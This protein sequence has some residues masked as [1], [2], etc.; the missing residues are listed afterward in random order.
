MGKTLTTDLKSGIIIIAFLAI[1]SSLAMSH[2]W[3]IVLF[4]LH[5]IRANGAPTDGLFRQQQVLLRSL[6]TPD[7]MLADIVKLWWIWRRYADRPLWRSLLHMGLSI[8]FI[9]ATITVSILSSQVVSSTDLQVLIQSPF[10]GPINLNSSDPNVYTSFTKLE[11][12]NAKM[13]AT[14]L[15]F[16]KECYRNNTDIPGNCRTFTRPN[17]PFVRR[18]VACPF[19]R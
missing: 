3:N 18:R 2:L 19:A 17:I 14:A 7:S 13:S 4:V 16:A 9:G 8:T 10:C 6:P 11:L 12:H 5:Q 1:L 15:R